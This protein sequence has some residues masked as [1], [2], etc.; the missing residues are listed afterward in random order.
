MGLLILI[1][2]GFI[3]MWLLIVLP[4]RR[5]QAAHVGMIESIEPGDYVVTAGGLYGTVT[6][7]GQED[8]GLEIAPDVEVRVAKRAI[9]AVIPPDEIEE[10][11]EI[12]ERADEGADAPAARVP[13]ESADPDRR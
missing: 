11:E 13:A 7:L 9:G 8:L 5:R 3:L 12:E 1:I 2:V 4:Q 6:E 10:I